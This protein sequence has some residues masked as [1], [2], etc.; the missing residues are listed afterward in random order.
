MWFFFWG[1]GGVPKSILPCEA[2]NGCAGELAVRVG[3]VERSG[4]V[5]GAGVLLGRRLCDVHEG[6]NI[7]AG[8]G[9]VQALP[10]HGVLIV[11]RADVE[12]LRTRMGEFERLAKITNITNVLMNALNSR[13]PQYAV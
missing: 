2:V 6:D 1:G 8:K 11:L 13:F 9:I 3:A 5:D 4:K 10:R 12:H 7:A